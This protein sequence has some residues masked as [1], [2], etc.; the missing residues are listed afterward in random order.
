MRPAKLDLT[1]T[2]NAQDPELSGGVFGDITGD[3]SVS[4][5][6]LLGAAAPTAGSPVTFIGAAIYRKKLTAAEMTIARA[7][8]LA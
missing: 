5:V 2:A 3:L 1:V 8:L 4:D 6:M 7:F